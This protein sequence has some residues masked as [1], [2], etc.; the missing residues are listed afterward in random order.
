MVVIIAPVIGPIVGGYL[1]DE[2]SWPWIF[3]INVPI[4]LFSAGVV[5]YFLKEKESEI[6]RYP[7]DW[8]GLILLTIGVGSL[9]ILLDKG[10][11]LDWYESNIIFALTVIATIS[12]IYFSIW[13]Y[14]QKYPIVDFSFFKN[15][16]FVIGTICVTLGFLIYFGSTVTVPLWLQTEQGYNAFWAGVAVAPIGIAPLFLSTT[17]GKIMSRVDLRNFV[18]ISFLLFSLGFFYQANFITEVNLS[19]IM[20]ARFFQGFGVAFFFLPLTQL[21]LSEISKEKYPSASGLFHF[22]RILIGSGFGTS[23]AIQIW[24]RLEIFHHARL[25]D[26]LTSYQTQ[27]MQFYDYLK[28]QNPIFTSEITTHLLDRLTEQQAYMLALND[29][30][31]MGG[32]M[33]LLLIPFVY[34]SKRPKSS[35]V[36]ASSVSH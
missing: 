34:L 15:R 6:Q 16:N 33:F 1:T 3:Y 25:A 20:K 8:I 18:A 31:W 19:T 7:I 30:A 11:D 2:Y 28:N 24:T 23:L 22:V 32:W 10:K 14:F 27:V 29:L 26:S 13:T 12:L 35:T 21:S 17:L 4:G 9:Q 5:W 36:V